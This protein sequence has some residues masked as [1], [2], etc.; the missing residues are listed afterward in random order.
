MVSPSHSQRTD[1]SLANSTGHIMCYRQYWLHTLT[2]IWARPNIQSHGLIATMTG[3]T[4]SGYR[5]V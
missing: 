4:I 2:Y 5:M 3:G 1:I